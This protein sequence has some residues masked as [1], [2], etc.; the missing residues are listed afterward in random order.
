MSDSAPS[1]LQEARRLLRDFERRHQALIRATGSI[2]WRTNG[3]GFEHESEEWAVVT[4]QPL[5]EARGDG[6]LALVHPDD[7]EAAAEAWHASVAAASPYHSEH[8]LRMANGEYRWHRDRGI[9]ILEEDGSVC[10][11]VGTC[12]DVHDRKLAEIEQQRFFSVGF[13]MTVVGGP[14]GRFKRCSPMWK[15]VL[16]WSEA[17][18][19][20]RPWLDFVHPDDREQTIQEAALL[21][22]AN[23]TISFENRFRAKGGSYRWI[24]WRARLYADEALIYGSATDVTLRKLAEEALRESEDHYRF[25]V[26]SSPQVPWTADPQGNITDISERWLE[27]TGLP[28]ADALGDGWAQFVHPEDLPRT[29]EAMTKSLE[30]GDSY[31]VENRFRMSD[32]TYRWIR[33]RAVPRKDEQGN[34]VRWYGYTEDIHAR[35]TAEMERE[36]MVAELESMVREQTLE[37]QQQLATLTESQ[38]RAKAAASASEAEHRLLD[39]ILDALPV[40]VIIADRDGRIVRD[41]AANRELWGVPPTTASWEQYGEWVGYWPQSGQRVQ[42]HEW[43]MARA[44]LHGETVRRELVEIERFGTGERRMDLNNAAPVRDAEGNVVGAVVAGLDVT[45]M[46]QAEERLRRNAQTFYELIQNNPFGVYVVDADFRL[47]QVSAGAHKVFENVRPLL[48]KDFAE[49]LRTVWQ[50]PFATEAIEHFRHTLETGEPYSSLRTVEHRGDIDEVEAYDWR[51]ERIELP[52]GR[53][54]VVC[55][56]YDLSERLQY[57]AAI[58]ESEERYRLV[59]SAT[60]DVVWDWDME[61]DEL[62]WNESLQTTYGYDPVQVPKAIGWWLEQVHPD[63]RARV[64]AGLDTAIGSGAEAWRDEYRFLKA[65]GSYLSVFDRGFIQRRDGK[66]LRMIGTMVDMTERLNAAEAIRESESRFRQIAESLPQIVWSTRPDGYHDFFNSRWYDYTG[67]ARNGERGWEWSDYLHPDDIERTQAAWK[68]SL[69]TGE[70]YSIEYRFKRAGD[71]TYRWFLGLAKPIRNDAGEIVRWFGSLTDI[72]YQKE[73]EAQ[74]GAANAALTQ[75]RDAALA[76]SKAKSEFLANMSHE[77]RT[78]LNGVLGMTSLLM[79]MGLQGEALDAART[80]ASSGE[81]LLRVID[82]ILDL[83]KI[84]A[85]R[86]EI[87]PTEISLDE[88]VKDV[89]ALYSAHARAKGIELKTVHPS[90]SRSTV[91][92]DSVRLRQVLSNLV[93][94]AVKFTH[95]GEVELGYSLESQQG[96]ATARFTVKD[97]GVGIPPE[98]LSAVFESFTQAD[99]S[100]QRRFGGT[101]LGLTICKKIVGLM[102][103]DVSVQSVVGEGSTFT[104]EI[105][106]QLAVPPDER[107]RSP[108]STDTCP[109]KPG[110]R[111]LLA[112]DNPVNVLVATALLDQLGCQTEVAEDGLRAIAMVAANR[113]DLVL[114]DVQMPLCDGLEA[115]RAIR[116]AEA[117]G[118]RGRLPIVALTA[119][120]MESDKKACLDAGMDGFLAKPVTLESLTASLRSIAT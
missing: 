102:G 4:G 20:S 99:G 103:G 69:E 44:L 84:E 65:D 38:E 66:P 89:A 11:W 54:G 55:H 48:G 73:M 118:A 71:G 42:A 29:M 88:V 78:P 108:Q 93:S 36:Q 95:E 18:L 107:P 77:I 34:I 50:E 106:L 97:T 101:G 82:D 92:A 37:L 111:V 9:P 43:A 112:E 72:Q 113:Y 60:S 74:L 52:D 62:V 51:I 90:E 3:E 1:E 2:V 80:I 24:S 49:V 27:L 25:M 61:T 70:D 76:A 63:D 64:A 26:D 79:S 119:N 53:H 31:D 68:H 13:D 67:M 23:D 46:W 14:D 45:E 81:T 94:N 17:E 19:T 32:G 86:M 7:R 8:R 105:P 104:V 6:W 85:G 114:M 96:V 12:E 15:E 5:Q 30:T 116:D 87:E 21:W 39:A 40:G 41:N 83:S 35:K 109:V 47:F 75:A 91:M 22:E 58:R 57:E 110:L 115:A 10:E 56:F 33:G 59:N 100:V 117:R 120:A 98:R 28:K 16:G